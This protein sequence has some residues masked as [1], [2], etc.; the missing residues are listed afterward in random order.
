L[1]SKG[2]VKV[3][4]DGFDIIFKQLLLKKYIFFITFILLFMFFI[5]SIQFFCRA[6]ILKSIPLDNPAAKI[7]VGNKFT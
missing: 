2:E 7:L 4:N 6:T 1:S 3:T 5:F